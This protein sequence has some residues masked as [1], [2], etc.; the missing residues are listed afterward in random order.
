[1]SK[2]KPSTVRHT[3]AIQ[4]DRTKRL[5]TAPPDQQIEQH[6]TELVHPATYA[7]LAT[8]HA[9]GLRERTLSLPVMVA[10]MLSLIWRQMGS[11]AEAVRVLQNEG[12]L[13]TSALMVSQQAVSERL[14]TLPAGLFERIFEAVLPR[15]QARHHARTRALTPVVAHARMHFTAVLALDGSTLDALLRKVGLLKDQ[16]QTPLAGRMAALLDIGSM[17]PH[18][19]WYEADSQAHDQRFWQ[20]VLAALEP[21]VLLVFDLGFVN[22]GLFDQL[23]AQGVFF[24]TRLKTN[25]AYQVEQV[26]A[27]DASVRDQIIVLGS[28]PCAYPMRLVEVRYQGTWHR[29]LTNVLDGEILSACDVAALY[30][31]RWRIEDA[32]KAVKRLL[33][34]AYFFGGA[35]NAIALQVWTTWLLY[36]V[37]VDLTD[38][39]A[40]TLG[41]R[42]Q[43]LS[44]EMVYRGLY[45]FTQAYHRGEAADPVVYLAAHAK[46][47]GIIK[48]KRR[49]KKD[50]TTSSSP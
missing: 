38:A 26:L 21:G 15:L 41:L 49:R 16:E 23:T 42:Y 30:R 44:V 9:M 34:L 28:A 22:Y 35:Q 1:M 39:V 4:R 20:R 17:L 14:R 12:F 11:V 6:L 8:Y 5:T 31:Q 29:Y 37:L 46:E 36:S 18:Q 47:L 19:L 2:K 50:L 25:A 13:W 40:E 7:Q 27:W 45:H 3:R 32:F 48:Q 43:A 33:G 10:F 24:I